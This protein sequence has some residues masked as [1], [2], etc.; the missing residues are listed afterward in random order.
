MEDLK[1]MKTEKNKKLTIKDLL[2][3]KAA[4]AKNQHKLIQIETGKGEEMTFITPTQKEIFD[5]IDQLDKLNKNDEAS[6]NDVIDVYSKLIYLHCPM[7]KDKDLLA[8]VE[9]ELKDREPSDIVFLIFE[10][11]DI[12][13]I[14]NKL[15]EASGIKV[16]NLQEQI[17]NS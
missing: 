2:A 8:E 12:T 4:K 14:G 1:K 7:L 17:K 9:E 5:Y 13:K 11:F 10:R 15:I 6:T 3:K 16:D